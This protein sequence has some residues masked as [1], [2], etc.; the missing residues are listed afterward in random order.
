MD[1]N[2]NIKSYMGE[3]FQ[4]TSDDTV[5]YKVQNIYNEVQNKP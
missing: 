4:L 1:K 2:I 5:S 3:K